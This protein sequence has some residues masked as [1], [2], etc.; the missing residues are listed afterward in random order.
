MQKLSFW[1]S[2][3]IPLFIAVLVTSLFGVAMIHSAIVHD[4]AFNGTNLD[5]KQLTQGLGLGLVLFFL[6]ARLDYHFFESWQ[7]P[8]YLGAI[9][10]LLLVE[11][12]G[13]TTSGSTRWLTVMGDTQIQPSEPAKILVILLLARFY[14]TN[15]HRVRRIP[16]FIFSMLQIAPLVALV[17]IEPDLGTTMVFLAIWLGMTFVA[18]ADWLHFL[19]LFV[20][21]I[22]LLIL[23]WNM[24]VITG[25]KV[26]IFQAYQ[27]TRL[28][29]FLDPEKDPAGEGY[30]LIQ[31]RNSVEDGG[32]LGQGYMEGYHNKGLYLK[33]RH[34]DFI[35]S[36]IAE[37]FGF[38][39]SIAAL[40][41]LTLII[42][43]IITVA[44]I[45]ADGYG[46]YICIGVATMFFFQVFVNVGMNL[47]LMPVTGI[48]LPLV[49][50]GS[51]SLWTNCIALGLVESVALR[52][53]REQLWYYRTGP[54][55][56]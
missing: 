38:V 49:S 52:H 4:P 7:L 51:S 24:D 9:G 56:E 41:L 46:R 39:G 44:R 12:L 50:H 10:S 16:V 40:A 19:T 15:E 3:D 36:V 53:R 28:A 33:I 18:G 23:A 14:V 11:I 35:F 32:L 42:L 29:L 54:G 34:A 37:E 17:F 30:N 22:P 8:I 26:P 1:R 2:F 31:S 47:G 25:G 48:P 21:V 55:R 5:F 45:A 27:K 20:I 43:R 6:M 13:I